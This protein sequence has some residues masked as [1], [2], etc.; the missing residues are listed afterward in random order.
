[1]FPVVRHDPA[2]GDSGG[3]GAASSSSAASAK[4]SKNVNE[5]KGQV[6][7]KR[8]KKDAVWGRVEVRK[9]EGNDV[10]AKLST[11]LH[12]AELRR[13]DAQAKSNRKQSSSRKQRGR[14]S[15]TGGDE[16]RLTGNKFALREEAFPL[17]LEALNEDIAHSIENL[18][19]DA[20]QRMEGM[21]VSRIR[22]PKK[23]KEEK[24]ETAKHSGIKLGGSL[25]EAMRLLQP[26][27]F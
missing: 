7:R 10:G 21:K 24:K 19:K 27:A 4:E 14:S 25:L 9:N 11:V 26:E 3:D 18:I 6:K 13:R 12:R 20:Q 23:A 1:M 8:E 15:K 16:E 17:D 2:S 5:K 22:L